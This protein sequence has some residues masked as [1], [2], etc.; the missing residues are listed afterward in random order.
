M[1][2][3]KPLCGIL[4]DSYYKDTCLVKMGDC[5]KH[6]KKCMDCEYR[7]LCGAGCRACACKETGTDY[8]GIAED[9]CHFFKNGWYER[10]M[11]VA[12]KYKGSFPV[13]SDIGQFK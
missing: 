9:S 12:E 8:L 10:A 11:A 13:Q 4:S 2:T 5:V 6:N 7:L 3:I 1:H